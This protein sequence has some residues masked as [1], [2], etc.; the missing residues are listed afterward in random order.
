[1]SYISILCYAI[2]FDITTSLLYI[3]RT[4]KNNNKTIE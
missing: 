2:R 4:L 1:M 3:F